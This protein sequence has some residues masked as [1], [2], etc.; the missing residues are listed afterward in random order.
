MSPLTAV[1][2]IAGLRSSAAVD[3]AMKLQQTIGMAK[4]AASNGN[5]DAALASLDKLQLQL[6]EWRAAITASATPAPTIEEKP[7]PPEQATP[8]S[9]NQTFVPEKCSRKSEPGSI[10]KVH[11][12]GKVIKTG[13]MFS[14]SFHTGS[15]PFRFALGSDE[16]PVAGWNKGL[17]GMCEGERRRL[18]VPWDLGYGADGGKGVPPYAD[19]QYDFELVEL[20]NPKAPP[21]RKNKRRRDKDAE[22]PDEL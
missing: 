8:F 17:E 1:L 15:Q 4:I 18:I 10:M 20:S 9:V 14:S 7:Q 12:I 5:Y 22:D 3:H 19:L 21:P 11:Y 6:N 13:K 2:L 16:A